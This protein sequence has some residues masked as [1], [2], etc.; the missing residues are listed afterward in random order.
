MLESKEVA[1]EATKKSFI[2]RATVE[3]AEYRACSK[4][5]GMMLM[6]VLRIHF[7]GYDDMAWDYM[8]IEHDSPIACKIGRRRATELAVA[9][10]L[11]KRPDDPSVLVGAEVIAKGVIGDDGMDTIYGYEKA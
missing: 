6:A 9:C 3:K 11:E 1:M 8:I 2:H 4:S 5:A 10:G 7:D